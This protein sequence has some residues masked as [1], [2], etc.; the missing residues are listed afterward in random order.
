MRIEISQPTPRNIGLSIAQ[1]VTPTIAIIAIP[2]TLA[3]F[4]NAV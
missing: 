3:A 1:R 2:T 4:F